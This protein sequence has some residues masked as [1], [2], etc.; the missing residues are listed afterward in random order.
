MLPDNQIRNSSI[1]V[2]QLDVRQNSFLFNKSSL[3]KELFSFTKSLIYGK[4]K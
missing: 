3:K 1:V 4:F 2:K